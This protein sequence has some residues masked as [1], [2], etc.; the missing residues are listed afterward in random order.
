MSDYLPHSADGSSRGMGIIYLARTLHGDFMVMIHNALRQCGNSTVTT[1][2]AL[3]HV[4]EK[5]DGLR[6]LYRN[7][8]SGSTHAPAPTSR[9]QVYC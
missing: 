9:T 4:P 2:M 8:S 6:R 7:S 3:E 5:L 1:D